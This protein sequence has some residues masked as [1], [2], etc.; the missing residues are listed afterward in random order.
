MLT[1]L[2]IG[3]I[4]GPAVSLYGSPTVSPV[5][6][7]AWANDPLPPRFP[8]SINFFALSHAAPPNVIEMAINNPVTIVPTSKPP[9]TTGP[10]GLMTATSTT[11]T[12]GSNAGTI[13][14][15]SAAFVTMSTQVPYSGLSCPVKIP[16][17]ASN[18]R[19]TS[20]TTAPAA[21]PTASM[22]NAVKVNGSNPPM[23]SPMITF[24]SLSENWNE[25]TS[26]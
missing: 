22:L 6:E 14:S 15:R 7:A 1:T 26:P 10:N 5:T 2:I 23:K 9:S 8:S 12:N 24:G 16:G 21:L 20:R 19:R 17:F 4:A 11:A 13:I 18:C 3:L 25:N